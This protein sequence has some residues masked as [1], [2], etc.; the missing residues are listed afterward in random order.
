M[1]VRIIQTVDVDD[2]FRKAIANDYGRLATRDEIVTHYT[3]AMFSLDDDVSFDYWQHANDD[4]GPCDERDCDLQL[5]HSGHHWS[6]RKI[7]PR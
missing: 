1:R 2:D 7:A 5:G 4:E 3:A 6:S